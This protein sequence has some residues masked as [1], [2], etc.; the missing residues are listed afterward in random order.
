MSSF[1]QWLTEL[2]STTNLQLLLLI[3]SGILAISLLVLALTRW[4]QSRPVWKCV[5]LSFVAHILF[6]GYAYGTRMISQSP[7]VAVQ[8]STPMRVN[9][10]EDVGDSLTGND[11]ENNPDSG[12]KSWDQFVNQQALPSVDELERPAI[13]SEVVVEK[14]FDRAVETPNSKSPMTDFLP[15]PPTI[16][17]PEFAATP[18]KSN[19]FSAGQFESTVD[20]QKID[21]VRRGEE[22]QQGEIQPP[23]FSP[24]EEIARQEVSNDFAPAVQAK[25]DDSDSFVKQLVE[26]EFQPSAQ[27]A[28]LPRPA[29][30]PD[31]KD[32]KPLRPIQRKNSYQVSS[33]T[34]RI[35]D[36]RPL[37]KIYS[38]RNIATRK[39][40]AL[41]RGG[42]LETERAV[43][44]S[45]KWL[46]KNQEPDGSWDS[47]KS[48]GGT[49]TKTFG[50]DRRGAGADAD[51]GITALATLSFLAAGHSH[52]EG[53]YQ[54]EIQKGLEFLVR[55]QT[56]SG[57]LA[58]NARLFAK[59]YCHSM[60]L[61]ALSEALAMTGD[62]RLMA[63]VQRGVNFS[64]AAQN[65]RD[66]GWRYA[67]G[68]AG[69]MSQ[70]GWQV[71]AL[72]SAKLGGAV[73]PKKS[74]DLMNEF[75]EACTSGIGKGIAS[76][77]P[78]Q[79]PSTTM[80]AEA[81]LCRYFLQKNVKPNTL[82]A[83]TGRISSERPTP[84][85]VNLYYWYYGTLAMYH[86]G[87]HEWK[88][89][90]KELKSTLLGLQIRE[91]EDA[92]SYPTNGLWGGY[93][94][95]VYATSMATLNLEVYYRYLPIY[96]E[97]ADAKEN[98][99]TRQR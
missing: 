7:A 47:E 38:L 83:A 85:H 75:L 51:C 84:H 78:N 92:G 10:V 32:I 77:R 5:I 31:F 40:I 81:L 46:A 80:T 43:E 24:T 98:Q 29:S 6:M 22:E 72:H 89:W 34:R 13:D 76:Y 74:M 39:E 3:G 52:L 63:P 66:G 23:P 65:R 95:Q 49:E 96:Q 50:H 14:V 8:E 1:T 70:F 90:N 26:A 54:E 71:L 91:G 36:G 99:G 28:S 93:G 18:E 64:V 19:E 15:S 87:G 48:G 82:M 33:S 44:L 20:P 16:E 73:V 35:S 68:D 88:A 67:P 55:Q 37:P 12:E 69:D 61:L 11:Q 45:L 97:L 9:L 27:A 86:S 58:G 30:A 56:N 42:S 21:V 59:M 60:S 62:Q 25:P 57:D 79:G 94:G 41:R 4:G 17:T 2:F 53:E